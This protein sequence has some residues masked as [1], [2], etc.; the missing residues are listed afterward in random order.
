MSIQV[1]GNLN[2]IELRH[3]NA[4]TSSIQVSDRYITTENLWKKQR[5]NPHEICEK[6]REGERHRKSILE[7]SILEI[8]YCVIEKEV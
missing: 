8:V 2:L 1:S 3:I 4:V 7:K 6:S 5:T